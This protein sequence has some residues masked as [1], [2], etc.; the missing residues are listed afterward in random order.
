MERDYPHC[1]MTINALKMINLRPRNRT[2]GDCVV[3]ALTFITG[4]SYSDVEDVIKLHH[5]RYMAPEGTRA[6]GVFTRSLFKD[7]FTI[8]GHKLTRVP[9][10][11][12]Q[13]RIWSF[14]QLNPKGTFLVCIPRHALVIKDGEQFDAIDSDVDKPVEEAW[15]VEKI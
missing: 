8:L 5:S 2:G 14:K 4:H 13:N 6:H 1:V 15:A 11:P 7:E 12:I 9:A 3:L 10:P